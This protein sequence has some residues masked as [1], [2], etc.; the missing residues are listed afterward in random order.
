M[1]EHGGGGAA[2]AAGPGA[3]VRVQGLVKRPT[4]L[5]TSVGNLKM[6]KNFTFHELQ[7]NLRMVAPEA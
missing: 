3:L 5:Q 4:Y 2:P 1:V 7:T 6:S